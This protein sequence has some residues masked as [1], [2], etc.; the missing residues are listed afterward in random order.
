[1]TEADIATVI[2]S[3][4][5]IPLTK[6]VATERDSLLK[7]GDELHRQGPGLGGCCSVGPGT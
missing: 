7:L 2:S 1:M 6:L 4:T 5:G 3:W